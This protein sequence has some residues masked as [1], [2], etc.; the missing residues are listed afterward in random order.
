MDN[1]LLAKD[2]GALADSV[3]WYALSDDAKAYEPNVRA[4]ATVVE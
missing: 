1:T 2:S 4:T 3:L